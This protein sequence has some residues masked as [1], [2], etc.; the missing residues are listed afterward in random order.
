MNWSMKTAGEAKQAPERKRRWRE[1]RRGELSESSWLN[2]LPLIESQ[3]FF[4]LVRAQRAD[5]FSAPADRCLYFRRPGLASDTDK[6]TWGWATRFCS[7]QLERRAFI[8][9]HIHIQVTCSV[10]LLS[11]VLTAFIT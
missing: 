5:V 3:S 4:S 11:L 7:L 6:A 1:G 10:V 8:Y 2:S 9:T